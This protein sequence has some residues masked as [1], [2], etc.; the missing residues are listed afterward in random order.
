[1]TASRSRRTRSTWL[2]VVVTVGALVAA[3]VLSVAGVRTLADSQVGR[4]AAGQRV[5]MPMQRMPFTPTALVGVLDDD[6]RLT[7]VVVLAVEPDGTGG[8]IVQIAA[9]A[10]TNSGN[11][12]V[13]APLNG[14]L[15]VSGPE[16]LRSAVETLAAVSFD[17]VELVDAERFAGLIAPLGDLPV[18][19]PITVYDTSEGVQWDAGADVMPGAEAARVLTAVAPD[20]PD[21]LFEP[22]RAA[23]WGAVAARVGAGIG[24]AQPVA[25]DRDL[26]QPSTLDELVARLFA[27]P[28]QFRALPVRPIADERVDDQLPVEIAEALGGAASR[29]VVVHDRAEMLMVMGAVAPGRMGAPLEAPSFRVVSGFTNDELAPLGYSNADVLNRAID[30]LLF[31][32]VNV[33]SV[34]ELPGAGVPDHSTFIVADPR[35]T[36]GVREQYERAFGDQIDVRAA[37]VLIEGVDIE[38]VLGRDFLDRMPTEPPADVAS[39]DEDDSDTTNNT[40]N[41]TGNDTGG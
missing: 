8:S 3:A 35:V 37:E 2:A 34:A 18:D 19:L 39:S 36:D 29:A 31:A 6:G 7:S 14:V 10:D 21:Y 38:L 13:L 28:V 23:I 1:M 9:T 11:T 15:A 32:Q 17:V 33:V 25:S 4:R 20:V 5:E 26:P 22:A 27:G 30:T 41:D 40:R 24:S 16:E 12:T